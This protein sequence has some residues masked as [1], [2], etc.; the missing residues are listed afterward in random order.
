MPDLVGGA[1]KAVEDLGRG[2][3]GVQDSAAQA[4]D[5]ATAGAR[6]AF[7]RCRRGA[8]GGGAEAGCVGG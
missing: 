5:G 2:L 3:A 6:A 8:G 4:V 1:S 7:S